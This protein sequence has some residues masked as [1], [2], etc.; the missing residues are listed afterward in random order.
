MI[1]VSFIAGGNTKLVTWYAHDVGFRAHTSGHFC[2]DKSGA[3]ST[4][5]I[6]P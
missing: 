4:S 6:A 1:K 3:K 2:V 5:V